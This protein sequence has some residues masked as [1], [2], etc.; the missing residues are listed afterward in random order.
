MATN[1]SYLKSKSAFEKARIAIMKRGNFLLENHPEVVEEYR[2]GATLTDLAQQYFPEDYKI[3]QNIAKNSVL[4][5]LTRLMNSEEKK[6]LGLEHKRNANKSRK[7]LNKNKRKKNPKRI[8][9]GKKAYNAGL[10]KLTS[11]ELSKYCIDNMKKKGIFPYEDKVRFV[12]TSLN[13]QQLLYP[14]NEKQYVLYLRE[15]G[16]KT[17]HKIENL[18]NQ[19][20]A[21]EG[22]NPRKANSIRVV[23]QIW[24]REDNANGNGNT[25]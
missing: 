8:A 19:E 12:N 10:S 16:G 5:A 15:Q 24:K 9:A 18:V 22:K 13:E 11:E 14:M 6:R 3:S 4:Y 7:D 23:Y 2:K 20:F 1:S 17:W 21:L 25:Q